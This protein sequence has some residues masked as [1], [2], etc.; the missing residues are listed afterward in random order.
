VSILVLQNVFRKVEFVPYVVLGGYCRG[1]KKGSEYSK[2]T[3]EE[4]GVV[5]WD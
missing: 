1:T 4:L 3:D 5:M 2:D